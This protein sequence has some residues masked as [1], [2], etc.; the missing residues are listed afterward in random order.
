MGRRAVRILCAEFQGLVSRRV[1][2]AL[3]RYQ[4][5]DDARTI[6]ACQQHNPANSKARAEL[7]LWHQADELGFFYPSAALVLLHPSARKGILSPAASA[8]T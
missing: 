5:R 8:R 1:S 4:G 6:E 2:A 7:T 3:P